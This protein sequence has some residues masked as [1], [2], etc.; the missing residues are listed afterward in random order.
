MI[1]TFNF[2]ANSFQEHNAVSTKEKREYMK[3]FFSGAT[4]ETLPWE[5]KNVLPT[6]IVSKE[7]YKKFRGHSM[8]SQ[9]LMTDAFFTN[10]AFCKLLFLS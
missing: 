4:S 5:V 7:F 2:M 1:D 8:N 3:A 10:L 6:F 9:R